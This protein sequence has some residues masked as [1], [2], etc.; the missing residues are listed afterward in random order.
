MSAF[1]I[2]D[3][4]VAE[5]ESNVVNFLTVSDNSNH[6]DYSTALFALGKT[7]KAEY[8]QIY[9]EAMQRC[10]ASN[11]QAVYQA[12]IAIE[13]LGECIFNSVS[14]IQDEVEMLKRAQTFLARGVRF[15]L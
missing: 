15:P 6:V 8:K 14:L 2:V 7:Y 11:S 13:N 4:N 5:T 3:F 10:L 1:G 9:I 12:G